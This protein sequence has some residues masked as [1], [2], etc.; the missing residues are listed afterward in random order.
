MS[1]P[2]I[3]Q[4]QKLFEEHN[5]LEVSQ[6]VSSN[7]SEVED[8]REKKEMLLF[9]SQSNYF[10]SKNKQALEDILKVKQ[11]MN[12]LACSS[13]ESAD[14]EIQRAKI[15][16]RLGEKDVSL[17]IYDKLL[18]NSEEK[19]SEGMRATIFHN[20]ANL[21]LEKGSFD[22]S[23]NLF[24]QAIEIDK[25]NNNEIGLAQSFSG[26]G[27]MYFYIGEYDQAIDYYRRSLKIRSKAKDLIGEA[28]LLLNLGSTYA[29]LLNEKN[30]LSYLSKA[31]KIFK[32]LK[33]QKGEQTTLN[34]KAR[35]YYSLKNYPLAVKSLKYLQTIA[36]KEISSPQISM[37]V[38]LIESLLKDKNTKEAERIVEKTLEAT[39]SFDTNKKAH[40]ITDIVKLMHLK[41]QYLF[42]QEKYE[43]SLEVLEKLEKLAIE[44]ND[45]KSKLAINFSKSQIFFVVNKLDIAKEL[46]QTGVKVASK[47][48]DPSLTAFLDLL[49]GISWKQ[50]DFK[51]CI[52]YSKEL[53]KYIHISRRAHLELIL[54]SLQIAENERITK[55]NFTEYKHLHKE[56]QILLLYQDLF[57]VILTGKVTL[58]KLEKLFK[59]LVTK[60]SDDLT[61]LIPYLL[62]TLNLIYINQDEREKLFPFPQNGSNLFSLLSRISR[63]Q[64]LPEDI[65]ENIEMLKQ[66]E[67]IPFHELLVILDIVFY[68]IIFGF[69]SKKYLLE[70]N[71]SSKIE[72]EQKNLVELKQEI[73]INIISNE[74]GLKSDLKDI[75]IGKN[76][77]FL[78][79]KILANSIREYEKTDGES[80][81]LLQGIIADIVVRTI[82]IISSGEISG[83][84][85]E[86]DD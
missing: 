47:H 9:S 12:E 1:N 7:L 38:L 15:L 34:T 25:R 10:L 27:G 20:L 52:H 75:P 40:H 79:K 74:H 14:I 2:L 64:V 53:S 21:Y 66:Q 60:L 78:C 50:S 80:I 56:F 28:T 26:L 58:S 55:V 51:E 36:V 19:L 83:T 59:G 30:A 86:K 33:H 16:R 76:A 8:I 45:E 85:T 13:E 46:A 18:K 65:R 57:S 70:N 49:F 41:S 82:A 22:Q 73:L 44:F 42:Q 31:E 81:K 32:K 43:Q 62:L 84:K 72:T 23:K 11:I 3:I 24:E 39:Q 68:G 6:I 69:I 67:S 17:Q 54:R 61:H 29:N 71:W 48:K 35:M 63:K 5:Y 4:I 77:K 37:L